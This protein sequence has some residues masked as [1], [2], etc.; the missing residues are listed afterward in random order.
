MRKGKFFLKG[1]NFK[2]NFL[3]KLTLSKRYGG[4]RKRT[5]VLTQGSFYFVAF[6]LQILIFRP[7][8]GKGL[9][10][11]PKGYVVGSFL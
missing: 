3:V 8:V 2:S 5:L 4:K 11:V 9:Q 6:D 7:L 1:K 10:Y